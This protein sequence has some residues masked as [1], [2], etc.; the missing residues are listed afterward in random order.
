MGA[1][2]R[3]EGER[4]LYGE[5]VAGTGA[6]QLVFLDQCATDIALAPVHARARK[7]ERAHGEAPRNHGKSLTPIA[8]MSTARMGE[9]MT[10]DA[11]VDGEAFEMCIE[12]WL[13]PSL[14]AG[15]VVMMDNLSV[16]KR[17]RVRE[18]IEARG[19][20]V[21]FLPSSSPD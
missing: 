16:H 1:D 14:A 10:L 13:A 18:T 20:S 6:E 11:A 19:C 17:D 7:G 12:R 2:E 4:A 5:R 15:P 3:D 9:A 8:S 21:L